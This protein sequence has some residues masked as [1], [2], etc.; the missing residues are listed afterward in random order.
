MM[1]GGYSLDSAEFAVSLPSVSHG[2]IMHRAM[3]EEVRVLAGR[4]RLGLMVQALGKRLL[5]AHGQCFATLLVLPSGTIYG[6][7]P[8]KTLLLVEIHTL[9]NDKRNAN[10]RTCIVG[11]LACKAP[12]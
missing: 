6:Q 7:S 3:D 8:G 1:R 2:V 10:F 5:I 4:L 12:V 11:A 9:H